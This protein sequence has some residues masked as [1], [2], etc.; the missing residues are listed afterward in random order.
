MRRSLRMAYITEECVA[1]GCCVKNCPT[2]AILIYKGLYAKPDESNC[3]GCGKCAK[4]CP[5][6]VIEIRERGTIKV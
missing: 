6:H 5:A 3:V 4:S 1:C 2:R